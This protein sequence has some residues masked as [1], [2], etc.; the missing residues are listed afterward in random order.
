MTRLHVGRHGPFWAS[1]GG[2]VAT[3]IY[4]VLLSCCCSTCSRTSVVSSG[5]GT[6]KARGNAFRRSARSRHPVAGCRCAPRPGARRSGSGRTSPPDTVIRSRSVGLDRFR[7]PIQVRS[8]AFAGRASAVWIT[9]PQGVVTT[10]ST[11]RDISLPSRP[12][13][14][15][16]YPAGCRSASP[17]AGPRGGRSAP[18]CRSP[19]RAGSRAPPPARRALRHPRPR[20]R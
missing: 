2:L 19:A 16:P 10:Q 7:H 14:S 17:S 1:A 13:E 8:L 5:P 3:L 6:L 9:V 18:P 12:H 4:L 11:D 15:H 20:Q